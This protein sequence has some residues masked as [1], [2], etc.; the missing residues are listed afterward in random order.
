[1]ILPH[2]IDLPTN[3]SMGSVNGHSD[4]SKPQ[5]RPPRDSKGWDGKLRINR[6]E[7]DEPSPPESENEDALPQREVAGET[8]EADEG[9]SIRK[10]GFFDLYTTIRGG[11]RESYADSPY[12]TDLLEEL[13][14]NE[15]VCS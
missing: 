15:T 4:S 10:V 13:D 3:C 11:V 14:E 2:D 12:S 6:N 1:M 5:P 7:P 8:L 9:K